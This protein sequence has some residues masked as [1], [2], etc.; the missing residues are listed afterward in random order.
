MGEPQENVRRAE[1]EWGKG[2]AALEIKMGILVLCSYVMLPTI[3]VPVLSRSES[4]SFEGWQR[5]NVATGVANPW[6][7]GRTAGRLNK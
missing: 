6:P 4:I 3:H 5:G 2:W 1:K 7:A